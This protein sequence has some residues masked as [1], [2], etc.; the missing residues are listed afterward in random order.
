MV[1]SADVF[2]AKYTDYGL[3]LSHPDLP[4]LQAVADMVSKNKKRAIFIGL[5]VV[6]IIAI[7]GWGIATNWHFIQGKP[8]YG[9]ATIKSLTANGDHSL[10]LEYVPDA[11]VKDADWA[12]RAIV[13]GTKSLGKITTTVASVDDKN[14]TLTTATGAYTG[15][16]AYVHDDKQDH[17]NVANK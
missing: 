6:V 14:K 10:T 12:G 4:M 17:I 9:F 11:K 13:I 3:G 7:L 5:A 1:L 2:A 15:T 16:V 8:G